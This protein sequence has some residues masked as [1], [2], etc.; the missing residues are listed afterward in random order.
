LSHLLGTATY[1]GLQCIISAADKKRMSAKKVLILCSKAIDKMPPN[2]VLWKSYAYLTDN[3][4][5]YCWRMIP[6]H[7]I[8]AIL[9]DTLLKLTT[10]LNL[11]HYWSTQQKFYT[12]SVITPKF[13][14]I[15]MGIY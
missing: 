3:K 14:C 1:Q 5:L 11:S 4:M 13:H 15:H 7:L 2:N 8:P 12:S 9:V 6:V 10:N